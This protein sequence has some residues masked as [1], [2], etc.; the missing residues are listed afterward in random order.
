MGGIQGPQVQA[1]RPQMMQSQMMQGAPRQPSMFEKLLGAASGIVGMF[2]PVAGAA[3]GAAQ[4][5]MSGDVG[6]FAQNLQTAASSGQQDQSTEDV[7][8]SV[9]KSGTSAT[10]SP[11]KPATPVDN[12]QQQA[13]TQPQQ[14]SPPWWMYQDPMLLM[15]L[16]YGM[17]PGMG[18]MGPMGQGLAGMGQQQQ[19]GMVQ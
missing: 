7:S 16:R 14:Q 12:Q 11:P 19:Q 1:Q 9:S 10:S 6:G 18:D 15:M 4:S 8:K 2:N 17:L 3:M 5:L 13:T